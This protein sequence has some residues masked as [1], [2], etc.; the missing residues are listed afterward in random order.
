MRIPPKGHEALP[1]SRCSG[2][3]PHRGSSGSAML[4]VDGGAALIRATSSVG[5][6]GLT[7]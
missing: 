1:H 3:V 5:E 7:T 4:S 2:L 6:K